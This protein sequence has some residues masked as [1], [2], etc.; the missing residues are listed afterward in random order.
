MYFLCFQCVTHETNGHTDGIWG[1]K[2]LQ[3]YKLFLNNQI[4]TII[5]WAS[6][7]GFRTEGRAAA[8]PNDTSVQ[9]DLRYK[10][11]AQKKRSAHLLYGTLG[12]ISASYRNLTDS[13]REEQAPSSRVGQDYQLAFFTPGRRPADAISRNWIRLIPN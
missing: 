3:S 8:G 7:S 5:F 4:I 11:W 2:E 1:H 6:Q 13:E 9:S 10:R 12:D